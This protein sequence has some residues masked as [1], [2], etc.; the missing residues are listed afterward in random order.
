MNNMV[1]RTIA[2]FSLIAAGAWSMTALPGAAGAA[3]VVVVKSLG[4]PA[5]RMGD[6]V[7]LSKAI[8]IPDGG[9]VQMIDAAGKK[10]Q[11]KGPIDKVWN[12]KADG[13]PPAAADAD[14]HSQSGLGVRIDVVKS[15]ANLLKT[16]VKDTS[17]VG[18]F[19]SLSGDSQPDPWVINVDEQGHYCTRPGQPVALWRGN[20][21][22]NATLSL[23]AGDG[24]N[25][26]DVTWPTGESQVAWPLEVAVRDGATYK[27]KLSGWA[28]PKTFTLHS[29]PKD[30]P[31]RGHQAAWMAENNCVDQAVLLVV[32]ADI[33]KLLDS[34][35][36]EF[37]Y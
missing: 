5:Y 12:T 18:A 27:A 21:S 1:I 22:G 28:A 11:I 23:A 2:I 4:A 25:A 8:N 9:V 14:A 20:K 26:T 16:A 3:E 24:P 32:S 19:R 33:D 31:T 6:I 36:R 10:I 7:D 30:L 13:T 37:K 34:M 17:G 15:L 29:L 35:A